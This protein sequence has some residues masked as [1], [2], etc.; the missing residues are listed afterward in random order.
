MAQ[1]K[2]VRFAALKTFNNVLEYPEDIKGKWHKHF[3][4]NNPIILELACG[5]GEYT[6][7]RAQANKDVNYIGVDV[8]GNRMYIGARNCKEQGITNAAYLRCQI[9]G[10]TNYFTEGEVSEI[11]IIFPDPFLRDSKENKRLTHQ[12]FL[13]KYQQILQ[14]GG[15]INLKTDS[16]Q[17]YEF[18][19]E[20]ITQAH[21]TIVTN[22]PN[23]YSNGEAPFPLSIKTHYEKMHLLD[24][25]IIKFISFTLPQHT[26]VLPPKK[27]LNEPKPQ[28]Q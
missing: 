20:V 9:D 8:K 27:N 22:N 15:L 26:I 4:N 19:Q 23:I 3:G 5:K 1:K 12:K 11:W 21:C 18:T 17:L 10:I 16:P 6:Q 14:P 25:R 28:V 7:H 2:L 24:N 13:Q